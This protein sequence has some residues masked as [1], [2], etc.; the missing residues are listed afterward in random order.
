MWIQQ[1]KSEHMHYLVGQ[2]MRWMVVR[3]YKLQK[4]IHTICEYNQT[5]RRADSQPSENQNPSNKTERVM[6]LKGPGFG[7]LLK[8]GTIRPKKTPRLNRELQNVN[9]LLRYVRRR[10]PHEYNVRFDLCPSTVQYCK[11]LISRGSKIK[12]WPNTYLVNKRMARKT[13]YDEKSTRHATDKHGG[14]KFS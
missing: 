7:L 11:K 12:E 8:L 14:L 2:T 10:L 6:V 5:G 3:R 1:L 13:P 4:R 9:L